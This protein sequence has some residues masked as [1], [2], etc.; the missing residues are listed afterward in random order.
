MNSKQT[1]I[2]LGAFALVLFAWLISPLLLSRNEPPQPSSSPALSFD[3]ARAY[4]A[5][6]DFVQRFPR[7]ILGSLESASL[8]D[9]C[10]TAFRNWDIA[11]PIRIS[12]RASPG[13]NRWDGM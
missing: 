7:R 4:T 12:T 11:S 5:T 6:R 1:K 2:Q 10:T 9:F 13:A 8:P 3:A